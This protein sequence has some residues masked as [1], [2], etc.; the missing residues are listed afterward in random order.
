MQ[1]VS[2]IVPSYNEKNNIPILLEK[3]DKLFKASTI[4]G[5]VILI[6]DGS[7][8]GTSHIIGELTQ[9]YKFLK[10][11]QHKK[12][13]GLT[14]ALITGFENANEDTIIFLCADMQAEPSESI[15]KLL[16]GINEGFDLV[17]GWWQ[18]RKGLEVLIS[19]LFS[20]IFKIMFKIKVHNP[21]SIKALKKE[22]AQNLPLRSSWHRFIV[23]IAH[24][25][26]YK[27]KEVK[28]NYYP[29]LYGKSKY[30]F[31]KF[32]ITFWDM[33]ILFYLIRTKKL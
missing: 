30:G 2:I 15:P 22:V 12:N 23:A 10:V 32:P 25:K 1:K 3:I 14:R 29:R 26:N 24:Y 21:T 5:E 6:D 13:E 8:D 18:G 17:C 31:M 9:K 33:M 16:E 27:V 4:Q 7:T 28:N 20:I 19:N 11:A